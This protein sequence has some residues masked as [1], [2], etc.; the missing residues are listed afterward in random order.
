MWVRKK[1]LSRCKA[2]ADCDQRPKVASHVEIEMKKES[3]MQEQG[4]WKW[5][6]K[7]MDQEI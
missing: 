1:K 7:I 3:I 4:I 5:K 2:K 6:T